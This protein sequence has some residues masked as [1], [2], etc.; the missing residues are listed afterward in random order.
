LAR[1]VLGSE[2]MDTPIHAPV[3]DDEHLGRTEDLD[4]QPDGVPHSI[5]GLTAFFA[6]MLAVLVVVVFFLG[7][8]VS[9]IG[10]VLLVAFAVPVIVS[11]LKR[12][13]ERERDHLH[14]SR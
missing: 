1:G 3:R 13:A 10:A 9:R 14:P 6:V 8:T 11:G 4:R 2:A 5:V 12:K 7:T